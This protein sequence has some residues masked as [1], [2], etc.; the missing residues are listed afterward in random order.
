MLYT[1]GKCFI[2]LYCVKLCEKREYSSCSA[3]IRQ[4]EYLSYMQTATNKM[5]T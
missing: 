3:E 5:C 4:V 1:A 2:I